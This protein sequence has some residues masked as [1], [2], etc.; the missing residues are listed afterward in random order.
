[1]R[2]SSR[3][4]DTEIDGRQL[5]LLQVCQSCGWVTIFPEETHDGDDKK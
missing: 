3:L 2:I 4:S 5:L 1:M